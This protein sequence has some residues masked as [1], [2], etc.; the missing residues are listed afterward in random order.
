M[1]HK[2]SLWWADYSFSLGRIYQYCSHSC[3]ARPSHDL[4]HQVQKR[5]SESSSISSPSQV[6]S[7]SPPMD[8]SS[9][10][11]I[12]MYLHVYTSPTQGGKYSPSL[13]D[14][15]GGGNYCLHTC[16]LTD[17]YNYTNARIL[18]SCMAVNHKG[19][20][21]RVSVLHP[22]PTTVLQVLK[23]QH[24]EEWKKA[25]M[26]EINLWLKNQ[27]WKKL[28]P[29]GTSFEHK[30]IFKIKVKSSGEI[31]HFKARLVAKGASQTYGM[32]YHETFVSIARPRAFE[33]YSPLWVPMVFI[34]YRLIL[35]Q[36]TLMLLFMMSFLW[37]CL[38][39]LKKNLIT[40]FQIVKGWSVEF[41]KGCMA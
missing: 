30:W 15:P 40:C 41:E 23:S 34:W 2:Y 14:D 3:S 13:E 19:G 37:I 26:D 11:Y 27:M 21:H 12:Y 5:L 38:L 24:S 31:E 8:G 39:G 9:P 10:R 7:S 18:T 17:I 33:L 25:M 20:A 36:H 28:P 29:R 22:W 32:D 35:N 16:S 4:S 6:F 1:R